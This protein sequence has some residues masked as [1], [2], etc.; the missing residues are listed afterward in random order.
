MNES[1]VEM[2][3]VEIFGQIRAQNDRQ[4][5][6]FKRVYSDSVHAFQFSS[7]AGLLGGT[8]YLAPPCIFRVAVWEFRDGEVVKRVW[9]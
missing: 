8:F 5:K 2:V 3:W 7:Y 6:I 4:L 9:G 1:P